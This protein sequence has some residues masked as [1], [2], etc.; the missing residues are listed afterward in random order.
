MKTKKLLSFVLAFIMILSV[1]PTAFAADIESI[2][3]NIVFLSEHGD[4][5]KNRDKQ[6]IELL[7]ES[8]DKIK[9]NP[10]APQ[11]EIDELYK[12]TADLREQL[13][14]CLNGEHDLIY[15]TEDCY[16]SL[17]TAKAYCEFCTFQETV[18]SGTGFRQ[19]HV[20]SDGDDICNSCNRIMP[21]VN[22]NHF[23]HSK[24]ILI[25][26][27]F[28]PIVRFIWD[29]LDIEEFCECGTHHNTSGSF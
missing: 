16:P 22:C 15:V 18:V 13:E 28:M 12:K 29:Y 7:K 3:E 23:C 25:Q 1:S 26:K 24:N 5:L 20:D 19:Q 2:E 8:L 14:D 27:I 17:C 9:T 21:Y 4:I 10:E 11:T 6:S